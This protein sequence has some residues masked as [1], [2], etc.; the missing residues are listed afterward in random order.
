MAR[1]DKFSTPLKNRI[2]CNMAS[3]NNNNNN[4]NSNSNNNNN[5]NSVDKSIL[6]GLFRI[7]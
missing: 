5:N 4:N 3:N 7:K 1:G 6:Y 2:T